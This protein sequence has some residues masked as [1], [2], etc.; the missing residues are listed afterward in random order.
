MRFLAASEPELDN[1]GGDH[2]YD[3]LHTGYYPGSVAGQRPDRHC[4]N[5]VDVLPHP[6]DRAGGDD[7]ASW[8]E[9]PGAPGHLPH[10]GLD[11]IEQRKS[12]Y[13]A[14]GVAYYRL[15]VFLI[16]DGAHG[17]LCYIWTFAPP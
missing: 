2:E 15:W 13:R 3:I 8:V 10:S 16:T 12:T 11:M 9:R 5:M 6:P 4:A 1:N 14:N 7:S 17:E